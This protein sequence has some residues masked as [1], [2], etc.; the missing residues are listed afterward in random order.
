MDC[1]RWFEQHSKL[2]AIL[3]TVGVTITAF[4][5]YLPTVAPSI[6]WQNGG[7]DSGEL[8]AAVATLGIPHPPGYPTYVLLGWG[9]SGLPLGGDLA[10]RLNL[11]SAMSAAVAAGLSALT[12]FLTGQKIVSNQTFVTI[13][14]ILAGLF[15]AL[16]PLTWSQATI[17]E[18]YAPGMAV[19][20]LFTLLLLWGQR[21]EHPLTLMGIGL[22][23]GLGVGVLPQLALAFPGAMGW[24][25]MSQR[26][27]GRT[28]LYLLSLL[29]GL[30][31][32]LTIFLFLPVRKWYFSFADLR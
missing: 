26:H 6:S 7:T 22:I 17:T 13:G 20:S 30:G 9:W 19:L 1:L 12:I 15:L 10:Y 24:I 11:L 5:V 4:M 16:A 21:T 8:A 27:S 28:K 31:L 29:G 23:G 18:V 2:S 32:G 3:L 14:A 25:Y